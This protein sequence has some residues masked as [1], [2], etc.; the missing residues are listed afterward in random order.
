MLNFV[1]KNSFPRILASAMVFGLLI[2]S[3]LI[4][5]G[6]QKK[7]EQPG[8][9]Q[10]VQQGTAKSDT[11]KKQDTTAK[12][13]GKQTTTAVAVDLKGTW[14]G[15]FDKRATTLRITDQTGND[16]KGKITIN[17]REVINQQVS[18]TIDPATNKVTMKD[19]LH[20]RFMG[21]YSGKLS[22]DMK[23][24]SGTFT[25]TLDGSKF[26]FNLAKK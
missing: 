24:L 10:N 1:F 13:T 23:Q 5:S 26:D 12:G 8:E 11:T 14:S 4:T 19:L 7:Q 22:N 6:C 16:F 3:V 9:K 2:S 15:K 20:S 25:M 21:K 17:Y 18:G